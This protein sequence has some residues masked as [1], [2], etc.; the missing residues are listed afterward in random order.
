MIFRILGEDNHTPHISELVKWCDIIDTAS[1][2]E[3]GLSV[4]DQLYPKEPAIILSKA[5]ETARNFA[6]KSVLRSEF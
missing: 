2:A 5:L 1:Y 4:R 6:T 3:N